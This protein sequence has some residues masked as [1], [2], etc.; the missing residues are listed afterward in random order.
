[1]MM[2]KRHISVPRLG[3][4]CKQRYWNTGTHGSKSPLGFQTGPSSGIVGP[5]LRAHLLEQSRDC[6]TPILDLPPFIVI[7]H[8]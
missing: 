4:H 5:H 6:T 7:A 2:L 1:M 3:R 8:L